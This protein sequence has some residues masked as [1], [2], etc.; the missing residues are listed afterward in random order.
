M[1]N[2]ESI[3]QGQYTNAAQAVYRAVFT[4]DR[5]WYC[6]YNYL[7]GNKGIYNNPFK[8]MRAEHREEWF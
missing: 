8:G 2:N 3:V 7:D 4:E 6:Y 1:T 5:D